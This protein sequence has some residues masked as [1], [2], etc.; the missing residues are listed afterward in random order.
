[1]LKHSRRLPNAP[2]KISGAVAGR[3]SE[4]MEMVQVGLN[5]KSGAA[6][7]GR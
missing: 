4:S 6:Q 1:M 3:T 7:F 2:N 5:L